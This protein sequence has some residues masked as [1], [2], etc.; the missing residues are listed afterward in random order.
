M[1]NAGSGAAFGDISD[2]IR[3]YQTRDL[4]EPVVADA[5]TPSDSDREIAGLY[6]GINPRQ[7]FSYFLDRVVGVQ[8]LWFED[9]ELKHKAL[10]GGDVSDYLPSGGGRY[11]SLDT[12][13]VVLVQTEDPVAGAVVHRGNQVLKP[14]SPVIAYGQ[15][16]IGALWLVA[17]G[18]SMLYFL[19]WGV[20]KLRGKI[21]AGPSTRIRVWPLLASVSIVAFV[22]LFAVG[23]SS[24]GNI[25]QTLGRPTGTSIGIM[26]ATITFA[27]FAILGFNTT[28]RARNEP[29]NRV[30]YW[31]NAV[32]S[33]L[34]LL[35]AIYLVSFGVIGLQTWA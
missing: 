26:I 25:F 21:P 31:Y 10:L 35:V 23:M 6:H 33:T 5:E 24:T 11:R 34:H 1:I 17:I 20:R 30:N 4:P 22:A 12:G 28:I 18:T 9:G 19:V 16:A 3:N 13:R 7:Q 15:L 14:V 2:L 32:C 27:A 8:K 29:M